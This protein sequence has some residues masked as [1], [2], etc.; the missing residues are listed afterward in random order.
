MLAQWSGAL[1]GLQFPA[2]SHWLTTTLTQVRLRESD[3]LMS[4]FDLCQHC[5]CPSPRPP[6]TDKI[7]FKKKVQQ[8]A[9]IKNPVLTSPPPPHTTVTSFLRVL[10]RRRFSIRRGLACEQLVAS[11]CARLCSV[12]RQCIFTHFSEVYQRPEDKASNWTQGRKAAA[13]G[14]STDQHVTTVAPA[15]S[16][17]DRREQLAMALLNATG[18]TGTLWY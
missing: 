3:V 8:K 10:W 1:T 2:S 18:M 9:E 13:N 5:T 7:F 15:G 4:S 11:T 14:G 17:R 16:L 12:A 6:H